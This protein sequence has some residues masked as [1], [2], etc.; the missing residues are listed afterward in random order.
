MVQRR[1]KGRNAH[2]FR[3]DAEENV[4]HGRIADKG[5]LADVI[6]RE[7]G[8]KR[9][10]LSYGVQ[11]LDYCVLKV[12]QPCLFIKHTVRNSGHNVFSITDLG[13]HHG[14]GDKNIAGIE[15]SK[16]SGYSGRSD[17]N[18]ESYIV[19]DPSRLDP[20][21]FSIVPDSDRDLPFALPYGIR[22]LLQG[23]VVYGKLLHLRIV[24]I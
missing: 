22:Q 15:I 6:Y 20:D 8:L 18:G 1:G 19:R 23:P 16:I 17:I 3:I 10:L 5:H 9:R 21:Y 24:L 4:M 2:I 7:S 12:L 14:F 13:V 11:T